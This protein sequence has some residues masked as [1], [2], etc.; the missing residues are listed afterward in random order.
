MHWHMPGNSPD[1]Q[2]HT[3]WAMIRRIE[4]TREYVTPMIKAL[5]LEGSYHLRQ[6]CNSDKPSPHCPFYPAYPDPGAQRPMSNDTTCQC[7]SPFTPWVQSMMAGLSPDEFELVVTDA[8]HDETDSRPTH[9]A[10]IWNNC[11]GMPLPC[12]LNITTVSQNV[13]ALLDEKIDAGADF[14][15]ASEIRMK[16]KSRQAILDVTVH[17][18]GSHAL[19]VKETDPDTLCRDINEYAYLYAKNMVPKDV[20]ARFEEHGTPFVF[21]D[22]KSP[23]VPAGP[24]WINSPLRFEKDTSNE[25]PVVRVTSTSFVLDMNN[26]LGKVAPGIVGIHYCKVLSPA[27]AVEWI[28]IQGLRDQLGY[29]P[30][31]PHA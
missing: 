15:S 26:P 14:I 4:Q 27:R 31:K 28:Y 23:A 6:P 18:N 29:E 1:K 19:D 24:F 22:D 8:F 2:E 25:T 13:Y 20:L 9:F 21:E 16:L 7:G 12:K 5:E 11:T 17:P 10:H 30:I 3:H